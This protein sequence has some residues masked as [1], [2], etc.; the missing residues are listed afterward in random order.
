MS[1][2]PDDRHVPDHPEDG[3]LSGLYGKPVHEHPRLAAVVDGL[4][5]KV[6]PSHGAAAGEDHH[7]GALLALCLIVSVRSLRSSVTVGRRIG[8]APAC[9]DS[10]GDGVFVDVPDLARGGV[11]VRLHYLGAGRKDGDRPA[12]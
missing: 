12:S 9:A 4:Q 5:R 8:T 3:R 2:K 7:I 10:R 1:R 11:S 6:H